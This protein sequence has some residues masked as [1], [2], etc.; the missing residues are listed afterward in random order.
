MHAVSEPT[1]GEKVDPFEDAILEAKDVEGY[2][3]IDAIGEFELFITQ[4]LRYE[5]FEYPEQVEEKLRI[6]DGLVEQAH[7]GFAMYIEKLT[8]IK[9]ELHGHP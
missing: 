6:F 9:E 1:W 8:K 3:L 5:I 2:A 7:R 4:D